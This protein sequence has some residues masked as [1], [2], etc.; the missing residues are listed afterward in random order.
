M[1]KGN[2]S[3]LKLRVA[4]AYFGSKIYVLADKSITMCSFISCMVSMLTMISSIKLM[5]IENLAYN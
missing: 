3:V 1:A 2:L 5:I 4:G